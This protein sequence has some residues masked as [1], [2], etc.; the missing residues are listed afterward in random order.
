LVRHSYQLVADVAA[1][2]IEIVRE[3]GH[4]IQVPDPE[5]RL[6]A[7]G[8]KC[9]S[10]LGRDFMVLMLNQRSSILSFPAR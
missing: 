8:E 9:Q 10:R 3:V 7:F 4:G 2:R 6:C 5:K 1:Q